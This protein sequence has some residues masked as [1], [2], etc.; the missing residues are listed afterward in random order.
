DSGAKLLVLSGRLCDRVPGHVPSDVLSGDMPNYTRGYVS[1]LVSSDAP[2]AE[3]GSCAELLSSGAPS[4]EEAEHQAA[5]QLEGAA[6][7]ILLMEDEVIA[8]E[9]TANLLPLAGPQHLAYVIYTSGSTGNPKGVMV[10]HRSYAGLA[11][12][13]KQA[14]RLDAFRVSLLQLASFSFDVFAGDMAR[15]LLWGG[16]MVICPSDVRMDPASLYE[17][18][19][20]YGINI[21]E[22]TPALVLPLMQYIEENNLDMSGMKL[23]ILGSDVCPAG[24]FQKLIRRF[25]SSMRILNS[26]GVTE[27]C[28]DSSFYEEGADAETAEGS[29]MNV[30]IGRPLPHVRMY[31]VNER[32]QLQPIGVP[33]ELCI[34]GIGVARGYLGRPEL[35]AEKFVADPFQPG[36]I[37]YRTGDTCRWLPDGNLEYGGRRDQQVKIRGYRMEL[38]EIEACLQ[39]QSS[40]KEG[41]VV[42]REDGQGDA[43]LCAYVVAEGELDAAELR[44]CMGQHLPGYMIPSFFVQLE[45]LP[46]TPNGKLDRRGMPSPEG[47]AVSGVEYVAPRTELEARLCEL[48]QRVLGVERV[49][50][51]D[52]F[53]DRGGHSLKATT[54]VAQMHK[55][56]NVNVPLRTIFQTSTLEELAQA[57][58]GMDR[59][60]YAAIEPVETRD[61]YPLSSAQKRMY[62]LNQLGGAELS[63]N[64][65]GVYTVEGPLNAERLEKAFHKLITRHESLR[66]SFAIDGGEPVQRVHQQIT[67]RVETERL[68]ERER[69]EDI[70]EEQLEQRVNSFV[71]PFAMDQAPLLRVGL[72]EVENERHLLL[73]DMH[74]IISDGVSMDILVQEFTRLYDGESLPELRIQ[75]KDYAVWQQKLAQ[76]EAM[77]Q[78][79][80]FWVKTFSGDIP[81]LELSTDY[82][83]PA[84]K[85]FAGDAVYFDIDQ[86]VTSGLQQIV[87]K[88]GAT[89]YM[90]LLAA[91]TALLAKYTGQEDI[92]VG[93]PIAGRPHAD[94]EP[95]IGIFI[96]TLALRNNPAGSQ[97]FTAFVH[98]VKERTL[99]A[100]ENQ[101]YPFEELVDKLNVRKDLSRS[102]LFD[103]M[104]VMQSAEEPDADI[105]ELQFIP[106]GTGHTTSK[107]DVSLY[108][109][110]ADGG[111]ACMLQFCTALFRKDT[112]ERMAGHFTQ[113]L[114][115]VTANPEVQLDEIEMFRDGER[116]LL[117]EFND[118]QRGYP[119]EKAIHEL[120]E[121][122][123]GKS[124]ERTAVV[125]G[126]KRLTYRELNERANRL[127][128]VLRTKGVT[129]NQIVGL[130][131]EP[132]LE[133]ITGMLGILKAGGAY[134]PLD[135][136]QQNERREHMLADSGVKLIVTHHS[137]GSS[138][139]RPCDVVYID[140]EWAETANTADTMNMVDTPLHS[141]N[142]S[143]DLVY[144]IYTSGT[145]GKPKGVPIKH[146]SLVNYASW[147]ADRIGLS[148]ED[149]T[150]L[151]S[152]YTFDLGYTGVFSSLISGGELHLM[153]KEQYVNTGQLWSYIGE[154]G[155]TYLKLTPSLFH[156]LVG[157]DFGRNGAKGE[158]LRWIVL[159]GE[160]IKVDDVERYRQQH[161]HTK[162]MNHYGPT[163]ATIGCIAQPIHELEWEA[164]K[165]QPVIGR[166]IANTEVYVVD[167]RMHLL[168]IG[169]AGEVV[170]GGDGL[171]EGYLH[172]PELT[173]QKF[174]RTKWSESVLYRTGDIGRYLS[175]GTIQLFGRSD[176]QIKMRGYRIES[177]EI[178]GCLRQLQGVTE[179]VVIVRDEAAEPLLCA[180]YVSDIRYTAG[181]IRTHLASSLPSYMI[182]SFFVS[183][184]ELPLTP[185][186]KLDRRALPSPEGAVDTGVEYVA[187]RTALEAKLAELWQRVLGTD[188]I[189]ARDNFFDLGGH[190]LKAVTLVA[191]MHK[192]LNVNVPLRIVF[193]APTLEQMAQA[194]AGMEQQLYAS[195]EPV[196]ARAHYPVSSAQKRLYILHQL[197]GAELSYNMPGVYAVEGL[198]DASRIQQVFVELI[199]R[200]ESLRTS[201]E[202][203]DGQPV[204]RVHEQVPFAVEIEHL[205]EQVRQTDTMETY[206]SQ[207]VEAFVRP[208]DLEQA[209][210]LRVGLIEVNKDRHLLLFDMHHIIS[211]G[212]SANI[213]VQEFAHIYEGKNLPE[214]RIQYKDYA[215]WQQELTQSETMQKQ[216]AFWLETFAG[217]I[218]VL[219][220]PTDYAR[221]A[222][223]SFEGDA[224]SFDIGQDITSGL[225][226]IA[227]ETGATMY[228]V[229]LA[230]YTA[231]L[232]KYTRQ[233]DIVIGTP[234][235]GRSHADL[236]PLIGMFVG[237]LAM[238]NYP[239]G[240]KTFSAFVRDVKER[241]LKAFEN[242]DYPFEELV[243]KLDVRKDLSR[244]PLFDA[245]FVLQ[246]IDRT[247]TE[248]HGLHF[249]PQ[250]TSHV[251][252][253]FDLTLYASEMNGEMACILQFST[254]LFRRDTMECMAGHFTELLRE[255][256]ED[257][258]RRLGDIGMFRKGERQL[259]V[260]FNATWSDYPRGKMVHQLFEEQAKKSPEQVA[261]VSG[262]QRL[263]YRE[264]NERADG[265]ARILRARGVIANQVV[266]LLTEPSLEMVI[267]LLG[268]LKAGGAYL[269]LD[270][271]H[272]NERMGYMIAESG[273]KL[274]LT[275]RSCPVHID[276]SCD[277]IYLDDDF[278]AEGSDGALLNA[279]YSPDDSAYVIYTSG[280]TGTPKG[281]TIKHSSLA[282]YG[283]WFTEQAGLTSVDKTAL[284]SSYAFDLGYTSLVSS[285]II[286]G[287][288]HL[289]KKE[290]YVNPDEMWPYIAKHG[291]TYLKMT[292]SLFHVLMNSEHSRVSHDGA[293][294][295]WIV[296]GGEK[297]RIDD[298]ERYAEHNANTRFMNH[299]GPTEATIGCIAQPIEMGRWETYKHRPIIGKPIANTKVY[300]VDQDMRQLPIGIVGEILIGGDG[301]AKGY[302]RQPELTAQKFILTEFADMP[303]YRTGDL[304]RYLPDGTIQLIGRSDDQ[305]KIRGYR[306][307]LGEVEAK[308]RELP[309]VQEAAVIVGDGSGEPALCAYYVSETDYTV[310][311]IRSRLTA[312]LP[313]YMIPSYCV[314][315]ERMPLTSNGK[316]NR[317]A[318]PAPEGRDLSDKEYVAP[319]TVLEL[320]LVDIWQR[321]LGIERIGIEDNF[322]DL[323]GHSLKILEVIHYIYRELG[324]ELPFRVIYEQQ[325][326]ER[327]SATIADQ[328]YKHEF[329]NHFTKYN[330]AGTL[331]VFCF[332]PIVGYGI[333]YK[334]LAGL[335]ND[336]I[337]V[338]ALD[339]IEEN[340]IKSC[341]DLIIDQQADG[342]YVFLGYSVGGNLAFEVAKEMERRGREVSDIILLD[343]VISIEKQ[344]VPDEILEAQV[345]YFI[346]GADEN[347][348]DYLKSK[349]VRRQVEHKM[350][351]YMR[352]RAEMINSGHVNA[353]L[354]CI[355]AENSSLKSGNGTMKGWEEA[356]TKNY[357]EYEGTGSHSDMLQ[358]SNLIKNARVI[359]QIIRKK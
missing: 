234:I 102:P 244:N 56:L 310:G 15:A 168:P 325:T 277:L 46:L 266:G 38:G 264:L 265:W 152:S 128:S 212:V 207:L 262:E 172:R 161:A 37:M 94:L 72:I 146:R 109:G 267:G 298:V 127:A 319:R 120:I 271:E 171:A 158:S 178:E 241:A 213:M 63:Y 173:E 134:L 166:P 338:Y 196:E 100:F 256:A 141:V 71:R 231:L 255:V 327:I 222:V 77:R 232:S 215:V 114:R 347:Y 7:G 235:A 98:D 216:E 273:M 106:R 89:M 75:Y 139:Q 225:Q 125:F 41:V 279:V 209:P 101:D 88:T 326:V 194:V 64:M 65:P 26:Y 200:H 248:V 243:E 142:T 341:A 122:Q 334:E 258:T 253:K 305:I 346:D 190:S 60:L 195:I 69:Q 357:M 81:V 356:T 214:L 103:T 117:V 223:Q 254:A 32:M 263:T 198:L 66:T 181:E 321:V 13:W 220:L 123:A 35:S 149:K 42:A 80:A 270:P 21:L 55:E 156:V 17:R 176:D 9:D 130:L 251:T 354:H 97:S 132:S 335:L 301:L 293:S 86:A 96:G 124:P 115:E 6:Y 110:E 67:F 229:L 90:V 320:Q 54:L 236:E 237:T 189:G 289:L 242:Q 350:I 79:E 10:E 336:E 25:G 315:L 4:E 131:A 183:L 138:I 18:I 20:E 199:A 276:H 288:L 52:N 318:L 359:A 33:G 148:P 238:R 339:F 53:F 107:F 343:S 165:H 332:P 36:Q 73:V 3:P 309:G 307:E 150:V 129:A 19:C 322:F 352:Y 27:A 164:Y 257:P 30:P 68:T 274:I 245:M 135:P 169:I 281:V 292:P 227:A 316:L 230:A 157:G 191:Q 153:D 285:L 151:V 170:I 49:G 348:A 167:K 12:A 240:D 85:S 206:I 306:I 337:A 219:N 160:A 355:L 34:G 119:K 104:F 121:E 329:G 113:L 8:R 57:V 224:V 1:D 136:E 187:P 44:R 349:A 180:Y 62:I 300:I 202:M 29:R 201:F 333:R 92:V 83:R 163:E 112:I 24:E 259:L 22:S 147:F 312:S 23:L 330:E 283:C 116:Q 278:T 143:E 268:I 84:V 48:W 5:M 308:L 99:Q 177:G 28:I 50:V 344:E 284:V 228:M 331:N 144:V 182:P 342:P 299:Y 303:L 286:G 58:D 345:Q 291:I 204:Q 74:H 290:Q 91:Y 233:E 39:Q 159:G 208:F 145:T 193:Q 272:Q 340:P 16:Q 78:Q 239:S 221:P 111:L 186:G 192:E 246:N 211:D 247:E 323:G 294:L 203:V 304:G 95:L 353:N 260:E 275:H 269:P 133:M 205:P 162:F 324:I 140:D 154:Q 47:Q 358:S 40:V 70:V 14:Y 108:A 59:Q 179:A 282:N 295:R 313:S 249:I 82:A 210:L 174:V 2:I 197:E 87:A 217:D 328:K 280:T 314:Q 317:R 11:H 51:K 296:L 175:D 155:I 302:V 137:C 126:E 45:E 250:G 226:Q 76:S 105:R 287:E 185:N 261:V 311:E 252:A 218:P 43:Y 188:R 118:T 297:I 31:V 184:D 93:T 351:S 61:Y